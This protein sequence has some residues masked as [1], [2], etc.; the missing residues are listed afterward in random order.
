MRP[1]GVEFQASLPA[2]LLSQMLR[3]AL[4]LAPNGGSSAGR[5]GALL[6][7]ASGVA[8]LVATDG[9]RLAYFETA[10]TTA[11]ILGDH[12]SVVPW[13][14]IAGVEQALRHAVLDAIVELARFGADLHFR[15]GDRHLYGGPVVDGFPD[16][17]PLLQED[18]AY[19]VLIDRG[20]FENAIK[21]VLAPL[22][23][24]DAGIRIRLEPGRLT[25]MAPTGVEPVSL[26]MDY[27]G[28]GVE[29]TLNSR[30]LIEALGVMDGPEITFHF[31]DSTGPVE[32]SP[33]QTAD[34]AIR[35]CIIMPLRI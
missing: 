4:S 25:V 24:S 35:R 17:E 3:M 10:H 29:I 18:Q 6:E 1:P 22:G 26:A 33:V 28:P 12:R 11:K 27:Q 14:T 2:G 20:E 23:I 21:H 34:G 16:Y 13:G 30:Y 7:I 9:H 8:R 31:G 5:T 15:V 19:S 32:I